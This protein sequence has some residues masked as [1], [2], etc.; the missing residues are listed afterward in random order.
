MTAAT[1]EPYQ[2][3]ARKYRPKTFRDMIGQ[4]AIAKTLKNAI[5]QGRVA[6][7]YLFTGPRG[8]GK[9]SA[10]RIMAK[11]LNCVACKDGFGEEPCN[12]CPPCKA[13]D[14]GANF[15]VEEFDA[16]TN[17]KVEDAEELLKRIPGQ[18]MREDTRHKVF[19]VDEV[20][21]MTSHAF[22][23]LLKTLEEPPAWVKFIFCTTEPESI[24][25]TILS[26]CQ[27]FDFR[28]ISRKAAFDRLKVI[29]KDEG[30]E[31]PDPVLM[32]LVRRARGGMRDSLMLLEQAAAFCGNKVEAKKLAEAMGLSSRGVA[33]KI[34][35][36]LATGQFASVLEAID[37]IY[38]EDGTT[39]EV[40]AQ[41]TLELARDLMMI[42]SLGKEKARKV[43]DDPESVEDLELL[44][45]AF[46]QENLLYCMSAIA[47][48]DRRLAQAKN[49]RVLVELAFLKLSQVK[50]LIPL[51]EALKKLEVA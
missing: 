26:R 1:A 35:K 49:D 2:V 37:E 45:G 5:R 42:A 13:I 19:I 36:S 40:V 41:R 27:R 12:I 18:P 10:A 15:D 6:H 48:L 28:P 3:M 25:D 17:R 51:G 11:A 32:G 7:A 21:M 8:T 9:T 16:A 14:S 34:F 46:S 23:A 33:I 31:I 50:D 29:A 22:N 47:E 30:I 39:A 38:A 4:D 24:P 44:A 43:L 20:H